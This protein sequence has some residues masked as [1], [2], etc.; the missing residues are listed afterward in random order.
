M[1]TSPSF[2]Y[3][4]MLRTTSETAVAMT[5]R[6]LCEKPARDAKARACWRAPTTSAED[7]IRTRTSFSSPASSSATAFLSAWGALVTAALRGALGRQRWR[8]EAHQHREHDEQPS[9]HQS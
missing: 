3:S 8:A 5:V 9:N 4:T 2:A 7:A 1:V 6:S